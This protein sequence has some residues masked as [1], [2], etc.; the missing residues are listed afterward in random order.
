MLFQTKNFYA[1]LSII[2]CLKIRMP[3]LSDEM[4]FF[5]CHLIIYFTILNSLIILEAPPSL[6]IHQST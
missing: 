2:A 6:S 1:M 5:K 4:A 3:S